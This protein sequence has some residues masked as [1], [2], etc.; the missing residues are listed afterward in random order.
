MSAG[1][2]DAVVDESGSQGDASA[3]LAEEEGLG[4]WEITIANSM[5]GTLALIL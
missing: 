1:D 4:D 5:S 2:V 3:L